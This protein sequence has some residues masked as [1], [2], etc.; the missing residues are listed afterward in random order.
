MIKNFPVPVSG[1][2]ASILHDFDLD[3]FPEFFFNFDAKVN[4]L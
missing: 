2:S 3:N 1:H 4:K